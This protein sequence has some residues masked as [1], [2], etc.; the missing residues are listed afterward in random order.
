M[1]T[2]TTTR[3]RWRRIVERMT[4]GW[5]IVKQVR[6]S[7]DLDATVHF[8]HDGQR[9]IELRNGSDQVLQQF[10]WG[11]AYIDEL[12][13]IGVTQARGGPDEAR[14]ESRAA[15][16]APLLGPLGL[17][18]LARP[19]IDQSSAACSASRVVTRPHNRNASSQPHGLPGR[20]EDAPQ[21]GASEPAG[22]WLACCGCARLMDAAPRTLCEGDHGPPALRIV[23]Q[24]QLYKA[25]QQ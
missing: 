16:D 10:V 19:T 18:L 1:T 4:L 8:Y 15:V 17:P 5:R 13:Q 7:A 24:H 3:E 2:T 20:V 6:N 25:A 23:S 12:V 9:L 22:A 14:A 11:L 21:F